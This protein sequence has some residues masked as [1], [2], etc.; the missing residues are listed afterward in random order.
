MNSDYLRMLQ[1]NFNFFRKKHYRSTSH[2]VGLS[3]IRQHFS[4]FGTC[5]LGTI[6]DQRYLYTNHIFVSSFVMRRKTT[7]KWGQSFM[8]G[9]KYVPK[10]I[11]NAGFMKL[12]LFKVVRYIV[13]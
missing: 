12:N 1:K 10:L 11:K 13:I 3:E 9:L 8:D 5:C 4:N 6:R 7:A 2:D